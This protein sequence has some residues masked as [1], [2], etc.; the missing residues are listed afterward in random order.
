MI[1]S[2]GYPRGHL[3]VEQSLKQLPHLINSPLKIPRRR[4]DILCYA[5]GEGSF[6]PI[7]LV[8]CKA[9]ALTEAV[10]WQVVGYNQFVQAPYVVLANA[11]EV[12]TGSRNPATGRY[13]FV[14]GLPR[15]EGLRLPH[16]SFCKTKQ[17][18]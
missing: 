7:L 12:R 17:G 2:L 5:K 13:E 15:Y 16:A 10:V 8:E 6:L 4:A 14:A 3:A 18:A 1:E 9:T 11:Q